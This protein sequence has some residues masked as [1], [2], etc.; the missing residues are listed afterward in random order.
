LQVDVITVEWQSYL[1]GLANREYPAYLLYWGAD[2]P[3]PESML[4][5]LFGEGLADNYVDYANPAFDALLGD[6]AREQDI[7]QR[8]ELYDQ[9]NQ[10]L[11]DDAVVLPLY[12]DVAYT[13]VRPWVQDLA[14]TPLGI[15]Y[16]DSVWI[17]GQAGD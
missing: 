5:T 3:D 7:E 2:Y 1:A 17:G 8:R 11:I 15:L 16:L 9:A 6:A 4:L 12:Y 10:L 13:L 14:V